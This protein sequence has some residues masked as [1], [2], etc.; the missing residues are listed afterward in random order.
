MLIASIPEIKYSLES[1]KHIAVDTVWLNVYLGVEFVMLVVSFLYHMWGIGKMD[2][3]EFK[4]P[5]EW[6]KWSSSTSSVEGEGDRLVNP[7]NTRKCR[8]YCFEWLK[9]KEQAFFDI[10]ICILLV[11]GMMGLAFCLVAQS[12][13]KLALSIL[14]CFYATS[15]IL[16]SLAKF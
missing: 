3:I 8:V 10:Q 14:L 9:K 1:G 7:T 5:K 15:E 11:L 13:L 16:V 12:F 4:G 2:S 6:F